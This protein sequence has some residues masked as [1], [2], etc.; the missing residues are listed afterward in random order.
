VIVGLG[1][2][3]VGYSVGP[4]GLALVV[5]TKWEYVGKDKSKMMNVP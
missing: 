4:P 2:A 1:V 3:G 5:G